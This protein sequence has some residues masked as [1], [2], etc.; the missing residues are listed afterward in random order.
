MMFPI[1][2]C[3][4]DSPLPGLRSCKTETRKLC[5]QI[6]SAPSILEDQNSL[7][8]LFTRRECAQLAPWVQKKSGMYRPWPILQRFVQRP[9]MP[10]EAESSGEDGRFGSIHDG[11]GPRSPDRSRMDEGLPWDGSLRGVL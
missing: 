10:L 3:E 5:G 4:W 6:L 1:S 9:R 11:T 7:F 8:C 2:F